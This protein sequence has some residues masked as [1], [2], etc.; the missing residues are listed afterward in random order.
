MSV[1][2]AVTRFADRTPCGAVTDVITSSI[3]AV[4]RRGPSRPQLALKAW[5]TDGDAPLVKT[6][7][8]RFPISTAVFVENAGTLNGTGWKRL[9]AVEKCARKIVQQ[10]VNITATFFV[11]RV[12]A[13]PAM[14][15]SPASVCVANK[16]SP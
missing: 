3:S 8:T 9:T 16:V 15:W 14:L 11:I 13:H 5:T 1:W 6:R 10:D 4:S 12:P 7:P 2:C